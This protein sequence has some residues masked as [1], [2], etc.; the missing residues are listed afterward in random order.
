MLGASYEGK[1]PMHMV[2]SYD[3]CDACKEQFAKGILL[4]EVT[5]TPN[6]RGQPAIDGSHYP[7][8]RIAVIT[9]E[10]LSRI[11]HEKFVHSVMKFRKALLSPETW[12]ELGLTE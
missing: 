1:A 6:K 11:F 9:E 12:A 8:G 10:A 7:T 5:S 3:P 4:V 2:L